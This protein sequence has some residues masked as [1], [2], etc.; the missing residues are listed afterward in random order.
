MKRTT[1]ERMKVNVWFTSP[2]LGTHLP[3]EDG[4]ALEPRVVFHRDENGHPCIPGGVLA[5]D[6]RRMAREHLKSRGLHT[7]DFLIEEENVP[8]LFNGDVKTVYR[9]LRTPD[10]QREC[11]LTTEMLPAGSTMEFTVVGFQEGF[12]EAIQE[13]LNH[14]IDHG[15]GPSERYGKFLWQ[16]VA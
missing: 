6:I 10:G 15:F 5:A 14:G 16:E 2:V 11:T 4:R 3:I 9:R 12:A 1:T 7:G 13:G 8:L